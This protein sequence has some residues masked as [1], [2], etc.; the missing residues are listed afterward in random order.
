[1][2]AIDPD[3]L[4]RLGL[5]GNQPSKAPEAQDRLGQQDFLKLM[6]TQL[7]NQ[8]PFQ[9]M[10]SGE[11]LGQIAQFGTVTGIEGLQQSFKDVARSLY[12][13]QALQAASLVDRNVLVPADVAV[14]DPQRGQRGAVDLPASASGVVVTVQDQTGAVVRRLSLGASASGLQEFHWDGLTD[15]GEVAPSGMYA[16]QA[17]VEQ[18]GKT[19]SV[20]VLLQ[21]RVNSVSL[22]NRDGSLTLQV[23]GLGEIEFSEARRIG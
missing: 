19:E 18:G 22:G 1:M 7:E 21:S 12:S 2:N 16:F 15:S 5:A 20:N 13:G 11:F 3:V 8:D 17:Q 4:S 9:P 23:D 10:E 6:V 14:L